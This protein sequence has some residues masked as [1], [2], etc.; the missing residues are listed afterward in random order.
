[1]I[2]FQPENLASFLKNEYDDSNFQPPPEAEEIKTKLENSHLVVVSGND[3]DLYLQTAISA[4]KSRKYGSS[5]CFLIASSNDWKQI[6]I[7]DAKLFVFLHPFGKDKFDSEKGKAMFSIM[8]NIVKSTT[9]KDNDD[10]IDVVIITDK[11]I[12]KEWKLHFSHSMVEEPIVVLKPETEDSPLHRFEE[13]LAS[14][15]KN[16]Y[17]SKFQPPQEAEKIKMKLENGH[18]AV[19]SGNDNGFYLQTAISA[20]KSRKYDSSNCFLIASSN[21]WKQIDIKDAKLVVFLH[22]FGTDTF[23]SEKGKNMFSIMDNIVESTTAK[24]NNDVV[25]VVI[26]TDQAL[27]KEW[28]LH[29]SHSMVED[30][31]V[32]LKPEPEN[33][34]LH[35]FE[36]N[37]ASFLKYE[38]DV[39]NF[40][41]PPEAE[42]IKTKLENSH[43]VV[44]SGND[45]DLYLQTAI[46]AIKSRKYGSSNCFLIASSNDW[47]Q[48]DIKDAKL[49]VFL[50]PF[51]KDKFDSEKGKAM[52]SIMD[53]IVKSTT[54]KDNDDVIDVVIITD[55]S[56]LKEWKLH[57][58]HSMV[59][60]PIVVLK[61]ETEDSPLHR[62]EENLASFLKNEYVSK[63]QPPQ[64]AEKIKTKLENSHLVVVS[65]NDNGFYLQ[66][67]ISAIKSRTYDSS[68]CFLITSSNDWKQIDIK[69]AKLVV[70]LHPFGTDTFDSEKGKNMVSIMDNI[71]ESTTAEDNSDVVDVVIITDQS[72][73]K[74][75]KLH[76]CHILMEDPI[77]VLKPEIRESPLHRQGKE[78][79]WNDWAKYVREKDVNAAKKLLNDDYLPN[80]E[81]LQLAFDN[82]T[83]D[84]EGRELLKGICRKIENHLMVTNE[85]IENVK[86]CYKH[87]DPGQKII[88][89]IQ[90]TSEPIKIDCQY[91]FHVIEKHDEQTNEEM[92][93]EKLYGYQIK[94]RFY[95][96]NEC[97]RIKSPGL[98][99]SHSNL[100]GTS[101]SPVKLRTLQDP[102]HTT[103]IVLYVEAKGYVPVGEDPLPLH[104]E[105]D[106]DTVF[107]TDVRECQY[108]I[109]TAGPSDRH[110]DLKI[111]CRIE[112]RKVPDGGTLG[113]FI[114][115]PDHGLCAITCSHVL[116]SVEE[117]DKFYNR[118]IS[119]QSLSK[120]QCFQPMQP[121]ICGEVCDVRLF[122]GNENKGGMDIAFVKIAESRKP[123]TP[124]FPDIFAD[125]EEMIGKRPPFIDDLLSQT[126]RYDPR[127]VIQ[128]SKQ[129]KDY[130]QVVKYGFKSKLTS[131][132]VHCFGSSRKFQ[133][134]GHFF[135]E[136]RN[137]KTKKRKSTYLLTDQIQI[138]DDY[139]QF[140]D[141]GDSGAM[142]FVT[143]ENKELMALG[144][145]TGR[146][147][148][149]KT[150]FVTPIWNVL[151]EIKMPSPYNLAEPRSAH[152][153]IEELRRRALLISKNCEDLTRVLGVLE[154]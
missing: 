6:D 137:A 134:D 29:F 80:Q 144:I 59:E 97:L 109:A 131:G 60:E 83:D 35:H 33:S 16:E 143:N 51:G 30:P 21:D 36:E 14:F 11:S 104:L 136:G 75:W 138:R 24:D 7:K 149:M 89:L 17:I 9:A 37:L 95:E 22:P 101:L 55:K 84:S 127:S 48:I 20:I 61:P 50:H 115:H 94:D 141:S 118:Q 77:V 132:I 150:T 73:L 12:L 68:N 62:F 133:I 28:K 88:F 90:T 1:M 32:V 120:I 124:S 13:N 122:K 47:K 130:S 69:D 125:A 31:I 114:D 2:F 25:D 27:L 103:C 85:S 49:V 40:Q 71:A 39:S 121:D 44:V 26:I 146:V 57:F 64:E 41:P 151:K 53:N 70:F 91:N 42:E 105:Y 76:F 72:I 113:G 8:D 23:D 148:Q 139:G 67:A 111:G 78:Y 38:Y 140:S 147:D 15:L 126:L 100:I 108:A 66:T 18:L 65:G 93:T 128:N 4:I 123:K 5:N 79:N 135:T 117:F 96:A 129:M 19:V 119:V 98:M 46:S 56:I 82:F 86:G 112:S 63:F 102:E 87:G 54:A 45:K 10:V 107:K 99:E 152:M 52:F 74:E 81:E 153:V 43:L 145:L 154:R 92:K 116:L 142:V 58:S 34:P 3:K 106:K 110:E